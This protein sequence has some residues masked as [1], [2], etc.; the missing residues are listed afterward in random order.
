[1]LQEGTAEYTPH[2]PIRTD[3]GHFSAVALRLGRC[4]PTGRKISHRLAAATGGERHMKSVT[5]II[6][7]KPGAGRLGRHV[8]HDP[9]SWAFSAGTAAIKTVTHIRHGKP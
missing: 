4:L 1:M 9:R 2:C 3:A 5:K 6:K 8:E 7:E